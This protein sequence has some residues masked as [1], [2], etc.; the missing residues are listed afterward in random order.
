M[1]LAADIVQVKPKPATAK[2]ISAAG[3]KGATVTA[4]IPADIALSPVNVTQDCPRQVPAVVTSINPSPAPRPKHDV[5][6]PTRPSFPCSEWASAGAKVIVGSEPTPAA[7]T[8]I[9][10][11]NS[12]LSC[13]TWRSAARTE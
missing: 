2:P 12:G 3:R 7:V 13:H 6:P 10:K 8:A 4:N 11:S 5:R 1:V 9:S